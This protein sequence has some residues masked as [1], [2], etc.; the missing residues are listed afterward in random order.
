MKSLQKHVNKE[1]ERHQQRTAQLDEFEDTTEKLALKAM[2]GLA[3]T[4]EVWDKVV[5]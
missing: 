3:N 4:K 1:Q 2:E 5:L